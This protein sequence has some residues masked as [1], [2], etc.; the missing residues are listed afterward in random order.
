MLVRFEFCQY[1]LLVPLIFLAFLGVEVRSV[2][3]LLAGVSL[4]GLVESYKYSLNKN[5]HLKYKVGVNF[6]I[7]VK[8]LL[9][10]YQNQSR[11]FDH[12]VGRAQGL[13]PRYFD[14]NLNLYRS[15]Q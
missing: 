15:R 4:E 5:P 1:F 7:R 9:A 3:I 6:I 12:R 10:L 8:L 11:L 2:M 14:H 13:L